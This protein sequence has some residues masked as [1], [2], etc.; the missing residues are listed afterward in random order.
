MAKKGLRITLPSAVDNAE[1]LRK[2]EH[3][4]GIEFTRGASNGGGENGYHQMIGDETL[5][6]EMRFHNQIK[7]ASVK[8]AAIQ[9]VLNQSNWRQLEDGTTASVLDG[10]DGADIMQVH[11]KTV[12]AILGGSNPTYER[13]IVSDQPF[14]YDGDDAV[15]YDAF[16]VCPDYATMV[17]SVLRSICGTSAAGSQGAGLGNNYSDPAFGVTNGAGR[18][19]TVLSRFAFETAARSK[20]ADATKNLPYTI[21]C[22]QDI[23]LAFAFMAIEFRTKIFNTLLGHGISSNAAPSAAT[24]GKVSGYRMTSDGGATYIYGTF[25]TLNLYVNGSTTA[26]NM[27]TVINGYYPLLKMFE[28]QLAVSD[29]EMLELVKDSDGNTIT[30]PMTGIWTKTFTFKVTAATT[31]GGEAKLYT[32]EVCLRVPMWRG[33]NRLWGNLSQWTGGYEFVRY[34]DNEGKTHHKAYRAPSVEALTTDSDTALKTAEG[35]FGFESTYD[36]LGELP[37]TTTIRGQWATQMFEKNNI[38]TAITQLEGG[39]MLNHEGA[40]NY[41]GVETEAGKYRRMGARLGG[42]AFSG[43]AVLRYAAASIEASYASAYFGSGFRV[44]LSV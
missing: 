7:I 3:Y 13:Y 1:G 10:S 39:T 44:K 41:I 38:M 11:T 34:L 40:A 29:G 32:V 9:T 17:G 12:Y 19:R 33:R 21:I 18:P 24:W 23:E 22:H 16:G 35:G 43:A 5:L 31:S 37:T 30:A 14:S 36:Y 8:D 20:N 28:G 6:A 26:T 27:W 25:G 2:L 42:F 15:A 4:Y